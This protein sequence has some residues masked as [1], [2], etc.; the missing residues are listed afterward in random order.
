MNAEDKELLLDHEKI[1]EEKKKYEQTLADREK[2]LQD[3][4]EGVLN[5]TAGKRIVWD[6]L[7]LLGYQKVMFSSDP[8]VMA[9]N[10]GVHDILL[11][12]IK[13]LEEASPGILFKIQNE[14]RSAQASKSN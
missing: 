1:A 9:A 14:Y 11:I 12:V 7:G 4:R 8:L 3:W 2:F 13:N 5:S 6:L 10:C